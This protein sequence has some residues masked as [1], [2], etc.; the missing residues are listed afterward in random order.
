MAKPAEKTIIKKRPEQNAPIAVYTV[1]PLIGTATVA[2]IAFFS[3]YF[4]SCYISPPYVIVGNKQY[5][6]MPI[7]QVFIGII[8]SIVISIPT[9]IFLFKKKRK[10]RF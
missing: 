5:D 7:P 9:Y 10:I 2:V 6:T 3:G 4:I 1:L 8:L